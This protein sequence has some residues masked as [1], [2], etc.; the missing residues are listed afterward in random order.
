[1][2]ALVAKINCF[3]IIN[4]HLATL[5]DASSASKKIFTWDVASFYVLPLIASVFLGYFISPTESLT[6]VLITSLSVFA[7][8][9]FNL[10][11][12]VLGVIE[13]NKGTTD[14]VK[15]QKETYAN[16]AYAILV[17]LVTVALLIIPYLITLPAQY[18][19]IRKVFWGVVFFLLINFALTMAMVLK[20][21]HAILVKLI[22]VP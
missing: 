21:M 6:N 15:L 9:L 17:S 1:M 19:L 13:K 5:V 16:I 11:M 22:Q 20:R 8:L 10:L 7:A 4:A 18:D 14:F 12:L 2:K 3:P